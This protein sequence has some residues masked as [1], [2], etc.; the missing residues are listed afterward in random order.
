M[1]N[2]GCKLNVSHA[3]SPYGGYGEF[4]ATFITDHS[5]SPLVPIFATGARP[6]ACWAKDALTKESIFFR[7]LR[8]IIQRLRLGDLAITPPADLLWTSEADAQS[9]DGVESSHGSPLSL[10]ADRCTQRLLCTPIC[11][12]SNGSW[13][14]ARSR[15]R[16]MVDSVRREALLSC[17]KRV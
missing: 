6:I 5:R 2:G 12:H 16:Y 9:A 15:A 7:L 13:Y 3:F 8:A 17:G 1:N 10:R 4:D 14:P 11:F